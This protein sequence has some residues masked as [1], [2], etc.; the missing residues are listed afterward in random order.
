[1]KVDS[2]DMSTVH[3]QKKV[4]CR[5]DGQDSGA[6]SLGVGV[7]MY[8]WHLAYRHAAE[9]GEVTPEANAERLSEFY[10]YSGAR[11]AYPYDFREDIGG[12]KR[13]TF[14]NGCVLL[15]PIFREREGL[16]PL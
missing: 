16:P 6:V 11:V 9:K 2:E 14:K 4:R 12:F 15:E 8:R 10:Q 1:M 3:S 5:H 13:T 7:D